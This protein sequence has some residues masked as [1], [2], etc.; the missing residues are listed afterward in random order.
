MSHFTREALAGLLIAV[1]CSP[2]WAQSGS[3][4]W[5]TFTDRSGTSVEYPRG[6]FSVE[7]GEDIP[8]GPLMTTPDGRARVHIFAL[9]N[10]SNETPAQYLR[11]EYPRDRRTLS[12]DRVSR[13]F[14][15]VSRAK[16][17]RILYRRC[18][19]SPDRMIHCIDIR[20]PLAAKRAFDPI[21][22]RISLSLQP[23]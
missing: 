13:N 17:G 1:L 10:E 14:F 23:R 7:A 11:R 2:A 19:F 9:S 3:L 15:A 4:G 21:V 8:R 16:D 20:Y 12:Y 22:T 18:N 5:S 6:L